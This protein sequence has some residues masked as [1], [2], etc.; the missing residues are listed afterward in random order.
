[1]KKFRK[2]LILFSLS[3]CSSVFA[4]TTQQK[5]SF[6]DICTTADYKPVL[7]KLPSGEFAGVAPDILQGFANKEGLTLRYMIFSY[8]GLIPAL[9]SNK[10]DLIATGMAA[11]EERKKIINF[12]LGMY[13]AQ[14]Y[15]I[16]AKNNQKLKDS[17]IL[18]DFNQVNLVAGIGS[19]SIYESFILKSDPIHKTNVK[20][21]DSESDI[22]TALLAGRIDFTFNG[23]QF[24]NSLTKLNPD[25]FNYI[26]LQMTN[27]DIAFGIR[28]NEEILL[29]KINSYIEELNKNGDHARILERNGVYFTGGY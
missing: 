16:Y 29:K 7:Y 11:T 27:A 24:L 19:G 12:T 21:F 5:N 1:L 8:N 18:Q 26:K 17:T 23:S 22:A 25:R 9:I 13:K 2:L 3:I 4:S 15:I 14:S 20:I 6:L 28:K 10:C